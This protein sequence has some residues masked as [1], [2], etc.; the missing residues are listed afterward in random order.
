MTPS[1]LSTAL[2]SSFIGT[3]FLLQWWQ[4]PAY[5]WIAWALLLGAAL[6]SMLL[7][8]R[9]NNRQT[10][11]MTAVAIGMM[12]ALFSVGRIS[13]PFPTTSVAHLRD[14]QRV[15]VHG[16]VAQRPDVRADRILY[17]LDADRVTLSGG[18][19][20]DVTG[21]V[22]VTDKNRWP[23]L[24]YGQEAAITGTL[25]WTDEQWY[26]DYLRLKH[27]EALLRATRV[28]PLDGRNGSLLAAALIRLRDRFEERIDLLFPE[29]SAS[30]L[31]GLLTGARRGLPADVSDAFRRTGLTHIIAVSGTNITIVLAV[32][33]SLLFFLPVRKRF[34]PAVLAITLFSAFVGGEASVVRACIMGILGLLALQAERVANVRLSILWTAALMLLWNPL[35]LW[36]DAGFQLSFLAVIGLTEFRDLLER[37]LRKVPQ[38]LGIREALLATLAAQITAVPWVVYRFELL[39]IV[40]PLA[41][42]LVAPLVPP[43]MLLGF[44]ATVLGTVSVPLGRLI[45]FLATGLLH[46]IVDIARILSDLPGAAVGTAGV[47]AWM[48]AGYYGALGAWMIG[49]QRRLRK[50]ACAPSAATVPA[51]V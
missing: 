3:L 26:A 27:T 29:P 43:A 13:Q 38:A 16:T 50:P 32:I 22:L 40:S 51:S 36:Y 30:L 25:E 4:Q 11:V 48:I 12:T 39:S 42:I 37:P 21:R 5:P 47:T 49:W 41:N 28:E 10:F 46:A 24:A 2:L 20:R 34:V 45:G 14:G 6:L 23:R 1:A 19:K 15:T 8:F 7:G 33:G 31:A 17:A 18:I 35:S 9:R 44:V